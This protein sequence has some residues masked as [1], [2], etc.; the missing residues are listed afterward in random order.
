[1]K[2]LNVLEKTVIGMA[3]TTTIITALPVLGEVGVISAAGK[4][5]SVTLSAFSALHDE[6]KNNK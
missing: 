2:L 5:V 1:M 4:V 3:A 6:M